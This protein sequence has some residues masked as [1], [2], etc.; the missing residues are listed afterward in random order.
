MMNT[1]T[2]E[3]QRWLSALACADETLLEEAWAKL[4]PPPGYRLLRPVEIGMTLLRA[5]VGGAGRAFNFGEATLTRA[6]VELAT[7]E[8]G[9]AYLL[10]RHPRRAE[11][12]AVFHALLQR[13]E[14][15]ARIEVSLVRPAEAARAAAAAATRA[16]AAAT[17][18]DFATLV[19]GDG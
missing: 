18:V 11:L 14:S 9:F 8:Q 4:V 13:G 5:R 10:G 1:P 3:Q 6:A 2:A 17:R 19:R 16:A 7:G 15:R 12:A